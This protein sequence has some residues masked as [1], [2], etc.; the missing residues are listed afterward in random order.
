MLGNLGH[1]GILISWVAALFAAGSYYRVQYA[2]DM[3]REWLNNARFAFFS[4]LAGIILA[5][6][7]LFIILY[8]HRYAYHYAWK[9]SSNNLPLQYIVSCFWEGQ[10]GSFLIWILWNGII[11]SVLI[12]TAKTREPLVMLVFSLLQV[13]LSTMVLGLYIG[14][15]RVGSSPFTLL[16]AVLDAPIFA[17]DPLFVPE[18][19]TGLNPLLQNI[20]M[21]IHPPI[22]FLGF[23]LA[24]VPFA[25]V[26]AGLLQ[27]DTTS[28]VDTVQVWLL[29]TIAVL[30]AGIMMGA[31]WAY[32]TLNFGGYWN[33]DP[34][35]NAILIPW[36]VMVAALHGIL[37]YKKKGQGLGFTTG[38]LLSGFVL[39]MYATFLTRSGILGNA[40]VHSFTDLG[41]SGQ[42]LIVL[43]LTLGTAVV[44]FWKNR[45]FYIGPST[46]QRISASSW[47]LWMTLG[48]ATLCLAAFQVL[49]PTSFPV[50]NKITAFLGFS[51]ELAPPADPLGFYA[52]FQCWFAIL[53]G[54]S[55]G[56]A[57]LIYWK[58]VS[59]YSSLEDALS[60]PLFI[61][62]L[63]SALVVLMG[64]VQNWVYIL[65]LFS[66]IYGFVASIVL[67]I[68]HYHLRK[69]A[70]GGLW[71]H[72]GFTL[73]LI[74]FVFSA[75][76]TRVVSRNLHISA[77]ES[78][79]PLHEVQEHVLLNRHQ[80]KELNGYHL[81]YDDAKVYAGEQD[82]LIS[83]D[84][85]L[86]TTYPDIKVLAEDHHESGKP[87]AHK[88]DTLRIKGENT[89][90]ELQLRHDGRSFTLRPRMQNNPQ[91]G[92]IASPDIHSFWNRD[93]YMHVTNF[94]D[95]EKVKWSE[96]F[97][98][99]I[100][101]GEVL[102]YA[103]LNIRLK[104]A[105][106]STAPKGVTL[107]QGDLAI[108]AEFAI[109]DGQERY[110]SQPLYL[111]R[112]RKV[113][114]YA[115]EVPALGLEMSIKKIDI[116]TGR[117]QC[118]LRTSQ[119][120]W[121][122]VKAIEMPHISLV[123]I[124]TVLMILGI[125]W[126]VLDKVTAPQ[127]SRF[128]HWRRALPDTES[129]IPPSLHIKTADLYRGTAANKT[130]EK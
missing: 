128:M 2:P 102:H 37:V 119:R 78:S 111:I 118:S 49:L 40:S 31:Y 117:L 6:I 30:G 36:L 54:F 92:F 79:L 112:D 53:F 83:K 55:A 23:A 130:L 115:D 4:H 42:L 58:G 70:L 59:D 80:E 96:A 65:L 89:Y 64:F 28:W 105:Q 26:I 29:T 56:I 16:S 15:L 25:Y 7:G 34:V 13:S 24:A 82:W 51:H 8:Q 11:G 122:T 104:A 52:K 3:K 35:E 33:W 126:A 84:I 108:V 43:L 74:G 18:D 113:R 45:R 66:A 39:I 93:L 50:V 32:E 9:H 73:M 22:I 60:K 1:I 116:R 77:T 67:V 10:E 20:W 75:G 48:M 90:Y 44:L 47:E 107:Q 94:P 120:D 101:E 27:Q 97:D 38:L 57:Q 85:L 81:R 91:M 99:D 62:L 98:F 127:G 68:D 76:H 125:A 46:E 72:A 69:G 17:I 121:I 41:L 61:S 21:V 103:D 88:G 19:G 12:K 71:A 86:A 109:E 106:A 110:T 123:W 14:G 124:G 95:Q 100:G 5:I 63:L 129:A 114:L 87:I